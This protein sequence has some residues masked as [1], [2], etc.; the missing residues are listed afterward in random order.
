M[1]GTVANI[2]FVQSFI[3]RDK[4]ALGIGESFSTRETK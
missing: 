4:R 3:S 2:R 1:M